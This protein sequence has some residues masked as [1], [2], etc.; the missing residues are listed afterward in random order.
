MS[1]FVDK[2]VVKHM[3]NQLKEKEIQINQ[4]DYLINDLN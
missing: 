3:E 2:W 1:G 4:K